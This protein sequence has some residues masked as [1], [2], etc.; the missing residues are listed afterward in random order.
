MDEK[1]YYGRGKDCDNK[2]LLA[3]IDDVFFSDD[4]GGRDFLNLLPKIY[5]DEYR[6]AYNN[7]V[8]QDEDGEM[9]AAIGAFDID[10]DVGGEDIKA[11]CIGNVAVSKSYRSKGYMIDLM[12]LA[13]EDMYARGVALSYL[14][15]Q[16]QRY[17][18]FGFETAGVSYKFHFNMQN[19]KHLYG[20]LESKLR[21]E[22]LDENDMETIKKIDELY[23]AN[24]V[25]AK[26]PLKDYFRILKSW[27][28]VP[29]V[30]FD[31]DDFAGYF[32]I[33]YE[34]TWVSEASVTK[35]DYYSEM[36]LA[37]L[38]VSGKHGIEINAAPFEAEKLGFLTE[39]SEG[40][41]ICGCESILVYDF[42]K[43]IRAY[44]K[45]KASYAKLADGELSVL[46]HGKYGDEKLKITVKNN[47]VEVEK[48]D[49]DVEIELGHHEATRVF[50]S[51]YTHDRAKI[52]TTAQ[53]WLPLP[54]FIFSADQM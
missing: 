21:A 3:L 5:H 51:N 11:C 52:N 15:G 24:A 37:A 19:A 9:R 25:H 18:Y 28:H 53:Q 23:S 17:G 16:R 6:P 50:F 46:I 44:L 14:G 33:N 12:K 10:L 7:F 34:N 2:K 40:M 8:V 49:G 22:K 30:L 26:R 31:G 1:L 27:R 45:A 47:A 13:V 36:L 42:E 39:N 54:A 35:Y 20:R 41:D 29:Y 4:E 48:F 32:V 43:T 38:S